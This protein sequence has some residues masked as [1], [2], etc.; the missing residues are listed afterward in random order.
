MSMHRSLITAF[1]AFAALVVAGA[2]S[3]GA[4][5]ASANVSAATAA[6][7]TI[8][9]FVGSAPSSLESHVAAPVNVMSVTA[10]SV[11]ES[12]ASKHSTTPL[13]AS[14]S[15]TSRSPAMMIVGGAA[16]IVGA[17]IGGQSGT[18]VMVGGGLLG[19]V[20]LWNYLK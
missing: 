7:D 19:L 9:L 14:S 11:R 4:Q 16:L 10:G 15:E 6:A 17:V 8:S 18:I 1:G 3:L 5:G 20:G 2:G 13:L 12:A